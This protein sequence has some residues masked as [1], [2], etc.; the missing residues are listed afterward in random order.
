MIV[1]NI[2]TALETGAWPPRWDTLAVESIPLYNQF[3]TGG[4]VFLPTAQLS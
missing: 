2:E 1:V 4:P 3:S